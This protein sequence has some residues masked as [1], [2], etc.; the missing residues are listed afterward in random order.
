MNYKSK[1]IT[2]VLL[3]TILFSNVIF[4]NEMIF[5][6]DNVNSE[7]LSEN[8]VNNFDNIKKIPKSSD[9]ITLRPNSDIAPYEWSPYT[10]ANVDESSPDGLYVATVENGDNTDV[11][12][13]FQDMPSDTVSVSSI[14]FYIH[15]KR[16][17][18]CGLGWSPK[19]AGSYLSSH[20]ATLTTD[21]VTYSHTWTGS[22]SK[23]DIDGMSF[24]LN[25]IAMFG[26]EIIYVDQIYCE[27]TYSTPIIP[28]AAP[29]SVATNEN[30]C[31]D[32]T[33][34]ITWTKSS[35]A[36]KY[37]LYE[38]TTSGG[39]YAIIG[40]ELGDVAST[41]VSKP[42][43]Q[44]RY[45]KVRAGNDGGWSS[46]SESYATVSWSRPPIPSLTA[47][48]TQTVYAHSSFTVA[49]S[50]V[51]T[52]V[53]EFDWE[54]SIDGGTYVDWSSSSSSTLFYD[55]PTGD[56]TY[57]FRLR[58][59]NNVFDQWSGYGSSG[60]ITVSTPSTPLNF[61]VSEE[62]CY[63]G[64]V[65]FSWTATSGASSYT[66]FEAT[67]SDGT[68]NVI[69]SGI[70]ETTTTLS[71][72]AE[73]TLYYK[74]KAVN[75][76]GDSDFSGLIE[77]TWSVPDLPTISS[78]VTQTV[79]TH[80][81]FSVIRDSVE[82]YVDGFEWEIS[83]DGGS[84]TFWSSSSLST[85]SY[86][87]SAEYHTYQFKLR[88]KNNVFDLWSG[89]GYSEIVTVSTSSIPLNVQTS[90]S[91]CYDGSVIIS[92]DAVAEATNYT[93]YEATTSD[94][95]YTA[96]ITDI[97]ETSIIVLE[98]TNGTRYYEVTALN[99]VGE[100]DFSDYISV[101]WSAPNTPTI[102]S[103]ITEVVDNHLS[104]SVIRDSVG[105]YVDEFDWEI[106]IDGG[107]YTDWSTSDYLT[108]SYDPV[109]E[110]HTYQFRLRV[111]NNDFGVWSEYGYSGILTITLLDTSFPLIDSP[112]DV[113]YIYGTTGHEI[114]WSVSDS[115]PNQYQ[116]FI[117]G[118]G[119]GINSWDGS[120]LTFNI[121]GL[122]KGTHN[123]TLS[124]GDI[125]GYWALDQVDV[126]VIKE[127]G[128]PGYEI[129]SLSAIF[130]I[131][132]IVSIFVAKR[133]R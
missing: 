67:T 56:H 40:S 49:R 20:A 50:A 125:E 38:A 81:S 60:I 118:V 57:Q 58:V 94:G 105:S 75:N 25:V 28:P 109:E 128:I 15:A 111:K 120:D 34:M 65:I 61:Q 116:L 14:T 24:K 37:Y 87:P 97:I 123:L 79:Y 115:N 69:R 19:V 33:T 62:T 66:L 6:D 72:D 18:T 31:Y 129:G 73:D 47:P 12:H 90:E 32:G 84:Y 130:L 21:Y 22:W 108:L 77:V 54:I 43:V 122:S 41:S 17:G 110:D 42:S 13:G 133:K 64:S 132:I 27:V 89:Y 23:S 1:F 68:Y 127:N 113:T 9:T 93:L 106:S 95:E 80:S 102:T 98:P 46:L 126:T 88:V 74:L 26:L 119:Q 86:D 53:D 39:I 44:T 35:G 96:I 99:D 70:T 103:P 71:K 5:Q 51:G 10:Y 16:I 101:S 29:T 78:P 30:P 82:S 4:L 100:S 48:I 11:E 117:D 52:Y 2:L 63:D 83:I 104:F 55:P 112:E 92:W 107:I 7:G 36:T 8:Q 85:L 131:S 124:V 114:T 3:S 76:V 121:D 91:I 45:Y 59:K